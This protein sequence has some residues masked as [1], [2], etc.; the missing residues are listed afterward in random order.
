MSRNRD[1][2]DSEALRIAPPKNEGQCAHCG[3]RRR[4]VDGICYVCRQIPSVLE[5]RRLERQ[6]A[7]SE[8]VRQAERKAQ[9][10]HPSQIAALEAKLAHE[11]AVRETVEAKLVDVATL[12]KALEKKTDENRRLQAKLRRFQEREQE[13]SAALGREHAQSLASEVERRRAV[14]RELHQLYA[15]L[16]EIETYC[17]SLL[18]E[19]MSAKAAPESEPEPEP[20]PEPASETTTEPSPPPDEEGPFDAAYFTF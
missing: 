5:S 6:I 13:R 15:K 3:A 9:A 12:R 14:E 8:A 18:L 7:Q 2:A 20:E 17:D 1:L 19:R 16:D 10:D 11:R 4:L